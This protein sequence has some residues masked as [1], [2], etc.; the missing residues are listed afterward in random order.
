MLACGGFGSN[1]DMRVKYNADMDDK[2]LSTDSVG[3][4]GDGLTM[5]VM[6]L[7]ITGVAVSR[8]LLTLVP[9]GT[10]AAEFASNPQYAGLQHLG[11]LWF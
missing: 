5:I 7:V 4:Q 10:T 6:F 2:I 9:A 11:Y 8:G 3:A 1:V